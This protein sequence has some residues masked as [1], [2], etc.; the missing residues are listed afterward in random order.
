M[1]P[2]KMVRWQFG[3]RND[4]LSLKDMHHRYL[5]VDRATVGQL[6]D[7]EDVPAILSGGE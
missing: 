1:F 3:E 5:V 4:L 7:D 2:Y 6:L